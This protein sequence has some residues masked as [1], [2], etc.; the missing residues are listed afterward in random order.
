MR[1]LLRLPSLWGTHNHFLLTVLCVPHLKKHP[2][3]LD[4]HFIL[5]LQ[6]PLSFLLHL[7]KNRTLILCF[8]KKHTMKHKIICPHL[9]KYPL[10]INGVLLSIHEVH[11]ARANDCQNTLLISPIRFFCTAF[12]NKSLFSCKKRKNKINCFH[13]S[14]FKKNQNKK[15]VKNEFALNA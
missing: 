9:L 6:D 8:R 11:I 4:I 10:F 7:L 13:S 3:N 14:K 2:E 12:Q 5:L 1:Q 15:D